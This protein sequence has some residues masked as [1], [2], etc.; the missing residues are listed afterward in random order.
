VH[1]AFGERAFESLQRAC[2]ERYGPLVFLRV[3]PDLDGVRDD[4]RFNRLVYQIFTRS[5]GAR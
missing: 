4:P 1:A 5:A 3:D 2:D